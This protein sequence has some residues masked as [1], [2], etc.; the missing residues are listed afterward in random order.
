MSIRC[1]GVYTCIEEFITS[2]RVRGKGIGGQLL[3]AA[4]TEAV[5]KDCY[6][7]Q[8][9]NPSQLGYPLYMHHGFGDIGKH[10][11]MEISQQKP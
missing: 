9:N 3:E 8:V 6:E 10:L 11:K 2:E 4:I 1:A 5:S 7:I